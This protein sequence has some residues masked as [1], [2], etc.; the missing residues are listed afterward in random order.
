MVYRGLNKINLLFSHKDRYVAGLKLGSLP[1]ERL[2][3]LADGGNGNIIFSHP[4]PIDTPFAL[5]FSY[6]EKFFFFRVGSNPI[7]QFDIERKEIVK[8]FDEVEL[9]GRTVPLQMYAFPDRP[10][11]V[12]TSSE[13][14]NITVIDYER[15]KVVARV[16][17][18]IYYPAPPNSVNMW[19]DISSDGNYLL[20]E[21]FEDAIM[22]WKVPEYSPVVE[23]PINDLTKTIF[24]AQSGNTGQ[25]QVNINLNRLEQIG[26]YIY[27]LLGRMILSIPK[28]EYLPG[29]YSEML[30]L[31]HLSS[32]WYFLVA[33]VGPEIEAFKISIIK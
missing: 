13:Y 31:S 23:N 3:F 15:N 10:L 19:L 22:V 14:P 18:D 4:V 5:A 17:G 26:F 16:F 24:I 28:R 32:G 29:A 1:T 12:V 2:L 6:D 33:Q 30:D 25:I 7:H 21:T 11:L 9:Q 20:A 8:I 27:D